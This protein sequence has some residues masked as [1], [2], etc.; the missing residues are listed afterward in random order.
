[1]VPMVV[2]IETTIVAT[3]ADD[4][5][6]VAVAVAAAAA[7]QAVTFFAVAVVPQSDLLRQLVGPAQRSD[8]EDR[9][10]GCVSPGAV[11]PATTQGQGRRGG[12]S[13]VHGYAQPFEQTLQTFIEMRGES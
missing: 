6:A 12:L 9:R 7:V 3:V 5:P 11:P 1:M 8:S 4:A 10:G 13:G 2:G